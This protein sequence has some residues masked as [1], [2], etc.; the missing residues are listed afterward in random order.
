MKKIVGLITLLCLVAFAKDALRLDLKAFRV[1]STTENGKVAE[2]LETAL[3]AKPGQVIEYQLEAANTSGFVLK[4]VALIIPIPA[5]TAYRAGSAVTLK[6]QDA[7]IAPQFSFDGGKVFSYPPIMRKV[8]IKKDGVE[9]E[10]NIEV[11]PDE[12]THVRWVL[13]EM[14]VKDIVKLKLRTTVR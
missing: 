4:G 12:F 5:T 2:K 11:K 9:A 14:P 8:K 3:D 10:H 1:I 7:V 13:T 6:L